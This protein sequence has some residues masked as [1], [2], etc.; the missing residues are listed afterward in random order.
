MSRSTMRRAIGALAIC[1]VLM[2]LLGAL[3]VD[4]IRSC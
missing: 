2:V 3:V 4:A 1:G